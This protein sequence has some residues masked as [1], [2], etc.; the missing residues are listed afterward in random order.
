MIVRIIDWIDACR[1]D[2]F[3][4]FDFESAQNG[5]AVQN[6][7]KRLKINILLCLQIDVESREHPWK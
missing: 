4:L 6:E 5:L 3:Y 2:I 7:N 1:D